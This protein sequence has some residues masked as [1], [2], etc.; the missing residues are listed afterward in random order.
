MLGR[1]MSRVIIID[2]SY[3]KCVL[4]PNNWVPISTFKRNLDDCELLVLMPLLER[5]AEV[6]DVSPLIRDSFGDHVEALKQLSLTNQEEQVEELN[7]KMKGHQIE[8]SG[9]INALGRLLTK[10]LRHR[11]I[12]L[13]LELRSDGFS[14]CA[15]SCAAQ[16]QAASICDG[17]QR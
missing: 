13:G 2:D 6:E 11:A 12:D 7:K 17:G 8:G 15:R 5:L 9:R 3:K 1:P 4:N 14:K 10:I 16:H